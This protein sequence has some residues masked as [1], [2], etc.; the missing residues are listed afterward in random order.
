MPV[1]GN[2]FDMP[3]D[4]QLIPVFNKWYDE[5]G[6]MVQFSIL[7]VNQIVLNTE[8]AA[9]DLFVQ[10]GNTYSDRGA[11]TAVNAIS[12]GRVTAIIDRSSKCN[13]TVPFITLLINV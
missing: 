5:Y 3:K 1:L 10:R 4:S 6:D 12:K 9:N 13:M 11:P 7:G 2:V 8:K